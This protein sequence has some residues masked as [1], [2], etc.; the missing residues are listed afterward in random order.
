ME[1]NFSFLDMIMICPY[2]KFSLLIFRS[3]Y[4]VSLYK[5]SLLNFQFFVSYIYKFEDTYL[6]HLSAV[7]FFDS[8]QNVA[9]IKLHILHSSPTLQSVGTE[10]F[11]S[12]LPSFHRSTG[13]IIRHDTII[14]S[15]P[16][17][18]AGSDATEK[19]TFFQ[20]AAAAVC[21]RI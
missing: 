11:R 9:I 6:L 14:C 1:C 3:V 21:V 15:S 17:N 20:A 5:I 10:S 4:A 12:F 16:T 18:F 13:V 2:T 8:L 19:Y 7:L